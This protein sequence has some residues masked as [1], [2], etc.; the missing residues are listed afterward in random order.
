MGGGYSS[1]VEVAGATSP[2][3]DFDYKKHLM[4]QTKMQAEVEETEQK[5][6]SNTYRQLGCK[7]VFTKGCPKLME[8][9]AYSTDIYTMFLD[10]VA[11]Y[12]SDVNLQGWRKYDDNGN[13]EMSYT[14]ASF[15]EVKAI[16]DQ[17]ACAL[18]KIDVVKDTNVG[19]FAKNR[20]EWFQCMVANSCLGARTVALYD[21]LGEEALEHILKQ[22]E[23]QV[24]FTEKHKLPTLKK[25]LSSVKH[26]VKTVVV[27]DH[28]EIYGNA[29]ESVGDE[30]QKEWGTTDDFPTVLVGMSAFLKKGDGVDV[31]SIRAKLEEDDLCNIM[32]T[33]GTTGLPK[34]VMLSHIGVMCAVAAA[35][36][37]IGD[38]LPAGGRHY[39]YLPL[40]HI[41]E[42]MVELACV[43]MGLGI[44]FT[45][46]NIKLLAED[47]GLVQPTLFIGVPRIYGKFF[48][49]FWAG[50]KG[51][52]AIKRKIAKTAFK[53]SS[54]YIRDNERSAVYDKILWKKVAKKMGLNKVKI[55]ITGAAPM[56]GYLMEFIKLV[57]GAP[58]VQ[59]YGLTET[60]ASGGISALDDTTVGHNGV[61]PMACEIRLA[62]VPEMN[63]THEDMQ[64]I[65]T[66]EKEVEVNCPRGEIQ[67]RGK[68]IFKGYYKMPEKTKEVM[69]DDGWFCT[70]DIGRLN[71]NG[72]LS[73]IDRKKNIFKLAQGEYIAVEKVENTY[74]KSAKVNQL[75]VYGNSYKRKIVAVVVP[76]ATWVVKEIIGDQFDCTADPATEPWIAEFHKQMESEELRKKVK[77]AVMAD[78]KLN[79]G[80]LKGFEKIAA[81]HCEFQLDALIQG[82]NVENNCLTPS[83][84]LKRPQ[85]KKRY[86]KELKALYTELGDPP[87]DGEEW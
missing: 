11:K 64:K 43:N 34:G 1:S 59:G 28:Q 69:T 45:Q 49:K 77:D 30:E 6:F 81:I 63:Y 16:V 55:S 50:V 27:F 7:E 20:P 12:G 72:T 87:K 71:P 62:D 17:I 82:F 75:W 4:A 54:I 32:Y 21:T 9:D 84:K 13:L 24:L 15:T 48:E 74:S 33:S 14:W 58:M 70:G 41:F 76:M 37:R 44:A 38:L 47:L 85:L 29:K 61:P 78:L 31:A 66:D 35:N 52:S 67:I 53:S 22:A 36:D 3:G 79:S 18:S 19:L 40:A 8:K 80:K 10:G 83:F 65:V 57:T 26:F 86:M 60:T 73:I 25:I 2:D 5:E 39:S 68:V 51:G 23:I 56:P 42:L 46:G